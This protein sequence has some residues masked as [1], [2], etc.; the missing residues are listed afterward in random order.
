M[1]HAANRDVQEPQ[2]VEEAAGVYARALFEV[3]SERG[4]LDTVREQLGQFVDALSADRQ[5]EIFF[6]SPY[7]S[8]AEKKNGL[9][10]MVEGAE[11][12]FMSFLETLV[13]RQRMPEIFHIRAR[14]EELW[15]AEMK[16]LP[17]EVTSAVALDEATV[18]SIGERIGSGTG[19][20]I[21]LTTVV[22]PD[23]LGGIVLRVGNVIL[24]ASIRNRLNQFR[25]HVAQA[26]LTSPAKEPPNADQA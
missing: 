10:R 16:L 15:D 3:A 19:N 13:E 11:E 23:M 18:R 2:L 8:T 26:R 4:V 20:K 5:L 25:K 24:D 12:T 1:E 17:V 22:D 6:V 14:Y 7:F 9:G 21:Q